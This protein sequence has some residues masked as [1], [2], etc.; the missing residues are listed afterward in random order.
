MF[1]VS[2][3]TGVLIVLSAIFL[4][5]REFFKAVQKQGV[6]F[7]QAKI[8]GNE[9][10]NTLLLDLQKSIDEMNRAF[11]EIANDLEGKYS[12][13]EKEIITLQNH[14]LQV[15][16]QLE[17]LKASAMSTTPETE[18][19]KHHTRLSIKSYEVQSQ[20]TMASREALEPQ[21]ESVEP[22]SSENQDV[23]I[24]ITS[25]LPIEDEEAIKINL[26]IAQGLDK[27]Q[28]AREMGMGMGA[29]ELMLKMKNITI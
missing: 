10:L 23:E 18:A 2:I 6:F 3:V 27:K 8:Y 21:V 15:T 12:I 13:H 14:W 7:E 17:Q 9:N 5:R 26:L 22:A 16:T 11:Y 1:I 24:P 20:L 29:L 4:L 25:E 28:I 19:I